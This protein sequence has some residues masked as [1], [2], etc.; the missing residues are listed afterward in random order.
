MNVCKVVDQKLD[1]RLI[2]YDKTE[3]TLGVPVFSKAFTRLAGDKIDR[4]KTGELHPIKNRPTYKG[5]EMLQLC[6]PSAVHWYINQL[7]YLLYGD[8]HIYYDNPVLYAARPIGLQKIEHDKSGSDG[9]LLTRKLKVYEVSDEAAVSIFALFYANEI[10]DTTTSGIHREAVSDNAGGLKYPRFSAD[11]L[12]KFR[13]TVRQV[14]NSILNK[15]SFK[16]G[17]RSIAT[18]GGKLAVRD[19]YGAS[20]NFATLFYWDRL[21]THINL[22]NTFG[23]NI[24]H[25]IH[26]AKS[27]KYAIHGW[28][29]EHGTLHSTSVATETMLTALRK[30]DKYLKTCKKGN[31]EHRVD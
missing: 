4:F 24:D 5:P 18:E 25:S 15:R 19:L 23:V 22:F 2:T 12:A 14:S 26:F 1:G 9:L 10:L 11:A 17:E 29:I 31:F 28:Y 30:A 8:Q 3:W 21:P 6:T 16:A 27:N 20:R 13:I 7:Q